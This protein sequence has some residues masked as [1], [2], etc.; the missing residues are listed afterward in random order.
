M[1]MGENN[2][3][4]DGHDG[5][6]V[7]RELCDGWMCEYLFIDQ[8]LATFASEMWRNKEKRPD[9]L[10]NIPDV[11]PIL[12]DVKTHKMRWAIR[13]GIDGFGVNHDQFVMMQTFERSVRLAVWY[14][15]IEKKDGIPVTG[16]AYTI[17][18]SR[19]AEHFRNKSPKEGYIYIPIECMNEWTS[20]IDLRNVCQKCNKKY[21][22]PSL[23]EIPV[24]S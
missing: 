14:A 5:E 23:D 24:K 11:A 7:F 15:F 1:F 17:P 22:I 12:I 16:K 4:Y 18:L 2:L 10:L 13:P 3:E 19:I 8:G 6:I 21:C 9:F 20:E